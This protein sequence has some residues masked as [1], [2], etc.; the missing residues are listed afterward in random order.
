M[1]ESYFSSLLLGYIQPISTYLASH[2]FKLVGL[3]KSAI[4]A[5][6]RERNEGLNSRLKGNILDNNALP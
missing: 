1:I 3:W 2:K 6:G 5:D 4:G